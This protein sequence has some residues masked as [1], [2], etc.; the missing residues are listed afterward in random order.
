MK[1]Y[2]GN[3]LTYILLLISIEVKLAIVLQASS[4]CVI[5][6]TVYSL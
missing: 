3:L 5:R 2:P 4:Y 6:L 1:G